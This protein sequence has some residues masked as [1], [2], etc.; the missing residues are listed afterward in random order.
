MA[1]ISDPQENQITC[2]ELAVQAKIKERQFP[3]P[4]AQLKSNAD[5]PNVLE[6]QGRLLAHDLAFIPW[7]L[8]SGSG[9]FVHADLLELKGRSTVN[10]SWELSIL[11][12]ND[13]AGYR[14]LA[15][16]GSV[17]KAGMR[18]PAEDGR[19]AATADFGIGDL[20][21]PKLPLVSS[22]LC[23]LCCIHFV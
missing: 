21:A 3:S 7:D 2:P 5:G 17:P 1:D 11:T 9:C 12:G 22:Y 4:M 15:G 6:F 10:R 20:I 8:G 16:T 23:Q 14:S 13:A 18:M 19:T